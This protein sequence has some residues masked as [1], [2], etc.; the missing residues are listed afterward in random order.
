MKTKLK[1][2][3]TVVVLVAGALLMGGCKSFNNS[4]FQAE[5]LAADSAIGSTHV[6]N[7]Y[8][9]QATNNATEQKI[10][11]L[12]FTRDQ[13]YGADR[14]LAS[15]L[16]LLDGLRASYETNSSPRT[17]AAINAALMSVQQ[18]STNIVMLVQQF[19][20]GPIGPP[21]YIRQP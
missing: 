3:V 21:F 20:G 13:L 8:Y 4:V 5:N 12:N 17:T 7:L 6:F 1:I 10:G 2:A 14:D 16:I 19:L 9:H 11:R 15:S 18:Q